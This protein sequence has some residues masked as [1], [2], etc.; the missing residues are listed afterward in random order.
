VQRRRLKAPSAALVISL[1]ALFVALGGTAYASGL[2]SGS[3][4]KN[5]SIPAKKL[6]ASAIKSLHRQRGP[7]GPPG[8]KG[9]SGP[10]GDT[11]AQ[12]PGAISFTKGDVPADGIQHEVTTIDG[13]NVVYYC[14]G[15]GVQLDLTAQTGT[16]Y[17]SGD[18]AMDGTLTSIQTSGPSVSAGGSSTV[19]LD[20]VA[21][22]GNVGTLTRFDL[23]GYYNGINACN[24]WGL[25]TPGGS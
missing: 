16:M 9:D 19:N 2:I 13:L 20:I 4:I 22:A 24:I 10:K 15:K 21:W 11:G 23:G 12:G 14:L 25:I 7:T 1:I 6:T 8:P 3:Q 17:A 18:D 5:H